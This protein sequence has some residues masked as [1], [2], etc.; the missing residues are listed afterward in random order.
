MLTNIKVTRANINEGVKATPNKCPIANSLA[1]K[2]NKIT[3]VSVLPDTT[4]ITLM[5]N[6]K[7][8]TYRASTPKHAGNFIR[9]FDDGKLVK[10]IQIK[11]NFV[12]AN[13]LSQV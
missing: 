10:P 2:F 1:S 12:K 9:K 6:K 5:K 13:L 7:T 8:V 4:T 3:Y 11:F